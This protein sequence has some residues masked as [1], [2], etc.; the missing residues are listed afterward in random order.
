MKLFLISEVDEVINAI[1][2]LLSDRSSMTTGAALP[3][4]GGFLA[5]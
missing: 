3:I 5:T 2:F 4:E 1:V